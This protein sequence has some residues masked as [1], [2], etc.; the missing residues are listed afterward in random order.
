MAGNH[1]LA[2][3]T[4]AQN[5]QGFSG[6]FLLLKAGAPTSGPSGDLGYSKGAICINTACTSGATVL[7]YNEGTAS[8][9]T[10]HNANG[11]A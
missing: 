11:E 9:P 6:P 4:K 1:R 8:N 5:T 2:D 10:W 7:Y 3:L